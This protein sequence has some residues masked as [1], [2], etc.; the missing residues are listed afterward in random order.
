MNRSQIADELASEIKELEE[1]D[2][3]HEYD[4]YVKQIIW[5]YVLVRDYFN[6]LPKGFRENFMEQER[7]LSEPYRLS[8]NGFENKQYQILVDEKRSAVM[9][10]KAGSFVLDSA[11]SSIGQINILK[12]IAT[13]LA[14]QGPR[15]VERAKQAL[16]AHRA[17]LSAAIA[18]F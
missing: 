2:S 7:R 18:G 14:I 5:T 8:E 15:C 9:I 11:Q 6:T 4:F 17:D 12:D 1:I 16:V 13:I 10:R 3:V